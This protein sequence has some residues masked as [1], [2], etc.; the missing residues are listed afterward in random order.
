[1]PLQTRAY[2]KLTTFYKGIQKEK[3]IGWLFAPT[4]F[5]R[6][7]PFQACPATIEPKKSKTHGD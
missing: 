1:M 2:E 4:A 3:G 6:T 5:L 7:V